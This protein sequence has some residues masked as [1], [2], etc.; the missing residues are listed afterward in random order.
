[1]ALARGLIR[2]TETKNGED[3]SVPLTGVALG[4][5]REWGTVRRI[6]TDRVFPFK[7]PA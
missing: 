7:Q 1:M 4:L 2:L 6:D 5:L 3:R